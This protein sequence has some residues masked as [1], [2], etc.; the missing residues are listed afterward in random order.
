MKNTILFG[1]ISLWIFSIVVPA[2][3][4]IADRGE[5]SIVLMCHTEEEPQESG[6]KDKLEEKFVA[7]EYLQEAF[8]IIIES[9]R[10]DE[11][12]LTLDSSHIL[13]IHLPPPEHNV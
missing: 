10:P 13:E 9:T 2:A 11:W 1:F 3:I 12:L 5:Q 4:T 8:S 6:K 7:D